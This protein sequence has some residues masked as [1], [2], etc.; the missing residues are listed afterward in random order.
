[1][2]VC[3]GMFLKLLRSD[4]CLKDYYY[5]VLLLFDIYNFFETM[6][7]VSLLLQKLVC[8]KLH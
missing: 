6:P 3:V 7:V 5:C 2:R 4:K 1:M 8:C